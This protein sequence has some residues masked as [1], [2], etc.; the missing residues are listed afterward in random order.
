MIHRPINQ[1]T[2]ELRQVS[3]QLVKAEAERTQFIEQVIVRL[4][5]LETHLKAL[6][7]G[8]V[9]RVQGKRLSQGGTNR[10]KSLKVS[11]YQTL[12]EMLC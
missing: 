2:A 3:V 5:T 8:A 12:L 11:C 9:G 1:I 7:S 6:E 10:H 4:D